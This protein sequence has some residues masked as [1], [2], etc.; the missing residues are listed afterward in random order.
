[1]ESS[2]HTHLFFE[3]FNQCRRVSPRRPMY[4]LIVGSDYCV[5]RFAY[6]LHMRRQ[7]LVLFSYLYTKPSELVLEFVFHYCTTPS[8]HNECVQTYIL[9]Q[10]L[11]APRWCFH[12]AEPHLCHTTLSRLW[13]RMYSVWLNFINQYAIRPSILKTIFMKRCQVEIMVFSFVLFHRDRFVKFWS[14]LRLRFSAAHLFKFFSCH[15]VFIL[16]S[17]SGV[18]NLSLHVCAACMLAYRCLKMKWCA[19]LTVLAIPSQKAVLKCPYISSGKIPVLT[20]CWSRA[21]LHD[22]QIL[23]PTSDCRLISASHLATGI[24]PAPF[25]SPGN[26]WIVQILHSERSAFI[27]Q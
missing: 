16:L 4:F 12:V 15:N 26:V 22:R 27:L 11:C 10:P 17:L 8:C 9:W 1:M 6:A 2:L 19:A 7:N 3:V 5:V 23:Q 20:L 24:I 13:T 14:L 25:I 21:L 18:T